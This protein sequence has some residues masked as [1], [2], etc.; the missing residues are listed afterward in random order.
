MTIGEKIRKKRKEKNLTQDELG[1]LCKMS[2]SMI[3]QYEL[4]LNKPKIETLRRI[5]TALDVK[6][7]YFLDLEPDEHTLLEKITGFSYRQL[8][9]YADAYDM[10]VGQFMTMITGRGV[11]FIKGALSGKKLEELNKKLDQLENDD[12]IADTIYAKEN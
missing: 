4:G 10:D 5:G 12:E 7:Y 9:I 11:E 6:V 8:K 3:R 2:G 1:A